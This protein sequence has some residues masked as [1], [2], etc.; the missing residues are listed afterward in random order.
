MIMRKVL[1]TIILISTSLILIA[2]SATQTDDITNLQKQVSALNCKSAKVGANLKTFIKATKSVHDSIFTRLSE[3]DLKVK[4]ISDTLLVK[5]SLIMKLKA[6]S[7]KNKSD[8]KKNNIFH[9]II[10]VLILILVF[11]I[12][13]K[14]QNKFKIMNVHNEAQVLKTKEGLEAELDKTRK[15]IADTKEELEKKIKD[16]KK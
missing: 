3:N 13:L 1:T 9:Y 12:Y 16:I 10:F 6:V 14:F 8:I 2:Q 15:Y 5:D 4:S 11:A 7:D